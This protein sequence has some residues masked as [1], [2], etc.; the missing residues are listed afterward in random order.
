[1]A[2]GMS[3]LVSEPR[4]QGPS[5]SSCYTCPVIAGG[6]RRGFSGQSQLPAVP[7]KPIVSLPATTGRYIMTQDF[8]CC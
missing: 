5:L 6:K 8:R 2:T 1:M 4:F 3:V 7:T